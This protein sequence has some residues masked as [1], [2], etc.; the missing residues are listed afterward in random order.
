MGVGIGAGLGVGVASEGP[1]VV[2]LDLELGAE[3][4]VAVTTTAGVGVAS[5]ET[6]DEEDAAFVL[7]TFPTK[8]NPAKPTSRAHIIPI[9]QYFFPFFVG[10]VFICRFFLWIPLLCTLSVVLQCRFGFQHFP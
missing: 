7:K 4:G 1:V 10:F 6:K 8:L 9:F 2:G 3:S 5:V